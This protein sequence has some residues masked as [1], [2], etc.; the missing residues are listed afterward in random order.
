MEYTV[1]RIL[2]LFLFTTINLYKVISLLY[3]HLYLVSVHFIATP[4]HVIP[5]S[6]EKINFYLSFIHLLCA[7]GPC[8]QGNRFISGKHP[9]ATASKLVAEKL[10]SPGK[11]HMITTIS[12]FTS[13]SI[14]GFTFSYINKMMHVWSNSSPV[15]LSV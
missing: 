8:C 3:F 9:E 10:S 4:L 2:F 6:V 5:F 11:T 7:S 14:S 15:I 13:G 1:C 12:G